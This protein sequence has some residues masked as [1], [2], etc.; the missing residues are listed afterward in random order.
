MEETIRKLASI[1]RISELNPIEGADAIEV[2]KVR[3]WNV[4]VK[5]GEFQV[6][7]L[8]VY[9]EIDSI[10]PDGLNKKDQV[11]VKALDKEI[12]T[13]KGSIKKLEQL[14]NEGEVVD[15]LNDMKLTLSD[16]EHQREEI[17][18]RNTRPEFEFLRRNKFRIKT[19]R[20]RGQISQGICFPLSVLDYPL[21]K[22]GLTMEVFEGLDVTNI[23]GV[24]KYEEPIPACLSGVKKGGFPSN[25]IKSDEE[26][27]QNLIDKLPMYRTHTW[28]V[29][30]KV[31]G[32][33]GTFILE[34][35]EFRVCSRNME[36]E[37]SEDNTYWKVAR[38]MNIEDKMRLWSKNNG[39][40]NFN[41]QG[42]IIGESIQGNHYRIVGQTLLPFR[43]FNIDK[44]EF[45]TYEEFLSMMEEMELE[46]VPI[47]ET[48]L[49]L[50]ET[51]EEL[52]E[53]ADGQSVLNPKVL[54]EGIVFV[55]TEPESKNDNG[56]LSFKVVSNKYILK[57]GK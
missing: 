17:V 36:L 8:C 5:K 27:V 33:S 35:G 28:Y 54:R 52:L 9:C 30:E 49:T 19:I 3:G 39:N 13:L 14:E 41:I 25:Q 43:A 16:L 53:Y 34:N 32:T 45:F 22:A 46:T 4:V 51:Y 6:G 12:S 29:T 7:D 37:E 20:L 44:F 26:R 42:E 21:K 10:L 23:L 2:A 1:Q 56:R 40:V 50:P 48:N 57:H 47:L 24:T 18:A 31:E 55:S 15:G 11:E 38:E